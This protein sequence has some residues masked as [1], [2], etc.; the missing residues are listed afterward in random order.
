[1][2]PQVIVLGGYFVPLGEHVL[3][4][5]RAVLNERLAAAQTRLPPSGRLSTLGIHAAAIGAAERSL[6]SV[7]SGQVELAPV[8]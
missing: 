4:P 3:A 5:A 2:D 8:P 6:Q 7:L 1:M